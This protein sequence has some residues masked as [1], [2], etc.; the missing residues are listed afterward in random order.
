MV[1]SQQNEINIKLDEEISIYLS[2][3]D[4]WEF[5][6]YWDP[7]FF[8]EKREHLKRISDILMRI[9]SGDLLRV[10]ISIAPRA[11]KSYIISLFCAWLIGLQPAGAVMRNSYSATLARKLS[12]DVRAIIRSE[13]FTRIFPGIELSPDKSAVDGW[14]T[15]SAKQVSYFCAGVG[16]SI[17]GFGCDVLAVLDDP[18]KNIQD[19]LSDV[20]SESVWNWYTSTHKSRLEKGCPEIHIATRWAKNDVIGRLIEEDYFDEILLIPAIDEEGR[21]YCEDLKPLDELLELKR[22]LPEF[23]FASEYQQQPI[24]IKGTLFP[25]GDL[26]FYQAS[27]IKN[28]DP[29]ISF[30]Y[31]DVATRGDDYL[32]APLIKVFG[33]SFFVDDVQYSQ[34]DTPLTEPV[35]IQRILDHNPNTIIF[36]SNSA[37]LVYGRSIQKEIIRFNKEIE[38]RNQELEEEDRTE[39][40]K[41]NF[42]FRP[43]TKNKETRILMSADVILKRFKFKEGYPPGSDYDKFMR[44]VTRY[45]KLKPN[46][47]DDSVDSLAGAVNYLRQT[48]KNV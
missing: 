47:E 33:G 41:T 38:E 6:K 17:T 14:N 30:I 25:R 36:E 40:I 12:Y 26:Q 8:N 34:E 9:H 32:S 48:V 21:S 45:I 35:L 28:K 37:G 18:I 23:I 16:G 43:E 2:R 44:S 4:F 5:C 13:K 20:K 3:L 11:G 1:K 27:T 29:D 10:A 46:Q 39:L 24:E 42:I 19:A 31:V 15:T 7:G 22:I